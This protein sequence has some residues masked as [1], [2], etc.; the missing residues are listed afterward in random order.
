MSLPYMKAAF[1]VTWLLGAFVIFFG[2][3]RFPSVTDGIVIAAVAILPPIVLWFWWNEP[4]PTM[5]QS[6]HEARNAPA[7]R[8]T[9]AARD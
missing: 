6:I 4:S 5:S 3:V 7:V 9:P 2:T 8:R 1:A